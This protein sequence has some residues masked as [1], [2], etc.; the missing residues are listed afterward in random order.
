MDRE[1]AVLNRFAPGTW[2]GSEAAVPPKPALEA[3]KFEELD[4]FF[5]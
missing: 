3:V 4:E 1:R 2:Q 5:L